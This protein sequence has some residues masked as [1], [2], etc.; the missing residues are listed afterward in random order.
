MASPGC[1]T[2]SGYGQGG[3]GMS[4]ASSW[5][6]S[7]LKWEKDATE[8]SDGIT[9]CRQAGC[10]ARGNFSPRHCRKEPGQLAGQENKAISC[11]KLSKSW[12]KQT[13]TCVLRHAVL[14]PCHVSYQPKA[15]LPPYRD[16]RWLVLVECWI[17]ICRMGIK[18]LFQAGLDIYIPVY[19]LCCVCEPNSDLHV[20]PERCTYR[21]WLLFQYEVFIPKAAFE[22]LVIYVI[23]NGI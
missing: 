23:I 18:L 9:D 19:M 14:F 5:L 15:R 10:P 3:G 1:S 2:C 4:E 8:A 20:W 11:Q 12:S 13:S 21:A 17:F 16:E 7:A 22:N 6:R